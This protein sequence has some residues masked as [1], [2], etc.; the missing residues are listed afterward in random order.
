MS[1]ITVTGGVAP[2]RAGAIRHARRLSKYEREYAF[3]AARGR[4][5]P[6]PRCS[7]WFERKRIGLLQGAKRPQYSKALTR[8]SQYHIS[9]TCHSVSGPGS[10]SFWGVTQLAEATDSPDSV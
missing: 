8:S 9:A 4:S 7:R 1:A 3:A 2:G 5:V 6:D 10:L